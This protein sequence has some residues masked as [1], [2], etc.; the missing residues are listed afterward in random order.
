[1]AKEN[2]MRM[3]QYHPKTGNITTFQPICNSNS[4][5]EP[6]CY[7]GA[8]LAPIGV[9][10]PMKFGC[11][12]R[13]PSPSISNSIVGYGGYLWKSRNPWISP[14]DIQISNGNPEMQ[15][16]TAH[17]INIVGFL[18]ISVYNLPLSNFC[19]QIF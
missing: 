15:S 3:L 14:L 19:L 8:S 4:W 2:H 6:N 12:M 17:N 18:Y 16:H 10:H 1:M 9:Q 5:V 13:F 11:W 7:F